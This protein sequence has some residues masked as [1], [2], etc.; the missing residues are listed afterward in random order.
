MVYRSVLFIL[1]TDGI[2]MCTDSKCTDGVLTYTDCFRCTENILKCTVH[3]VLI[4]Y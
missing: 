3:G 4:V 1:C 2:L